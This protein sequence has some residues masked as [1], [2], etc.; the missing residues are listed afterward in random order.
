MSADFTIHDGGSIVL[1]RPV[2]NAARD[3]ADTFLPPDAQTLG[4]SIAIER[5]YIG[6]IV[7]GIID[8]GL[9]IGTT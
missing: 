2:S 6:D 3:W 7:E 5:R 8:A 9:T 4:P 1:L